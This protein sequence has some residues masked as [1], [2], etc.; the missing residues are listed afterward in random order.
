[1]AACHLPVFPV[2]AA[3]L[4]VL[5][6]GPEEVTVMVLSVGGRKDVVVPQQS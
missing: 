5:M 3:R 1:V 2:Q 6:S 4:P